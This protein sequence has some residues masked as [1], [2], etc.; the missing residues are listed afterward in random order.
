MY[1]PIMI[2]NNRH[3]IMKLTTIL[4]V[5]ISI[6]LTSCN[7]QNTIK[8]ETLLN[9]N[10]SILTGDTVKELGKNIM[11][12]YQDR[13]NVYWLGSW[14]T[15]LYKYD[16][17]TIINYT[18]K[19]GLPHN[20]IEEIK[21]DKIGNIYINTS[22]GLCK[23]DGINMA[24]ITETISIENKWNLTP[25]DLWF[26]N[27]KQGHVYR[28]DGKML[29]SLEI[30]KTKIG[31]DY[32][33]KHPGYTDPYTVYCNYKDRK[34]NVWFGTAL[35]GAFRY[36]GNTFDWITEDDVTEIHNGPANGVRS[37]AED[38]EGCFWFNTSYR[39]HIYDSIPL[40][41]KTFYE[42]QKSIGS[43]DGKKESQ[44]N[45]YLS[46]V[47]DNNGN[48]WMATYQDGVWMYDGKKVTHYSFQLYSK[49]ITI[50]CIFK[51]NQGDLWLGTENNG[52]FKFNGQHFEQFKR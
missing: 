28:Y 33:L 49:K 48:L 22:K 4:L 42:R 21:E 9:T 31:E 27:P 50:F 2:L 26:K 39:Y 18:T 8:T 12:V 1:Y 34:G 45:E 25:D 52:A 37:I 51:D 13:K 16:G 44:L 47:T 38:K 23:Y 40:N 35:L 46:I 30:P 32:V 43:L 41:A 24:T 10:I 29:Y 15:G 11:L 5:T 6:G 3:S 36:N 7:G 20:R 19:H 17:K 14:K